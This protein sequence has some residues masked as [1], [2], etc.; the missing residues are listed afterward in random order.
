MGTLNQII[1]LSVNY[2]LPKTQRNI[3][4]YSEMGWNC[5]FVHTQGPD[6]QVVHSNHSLY[7]QECVHYLGEVHPFG[8]TLNHM[9]S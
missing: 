3:L 2:S 5:C 1:W 9:H 4:T 6:P 7:I 8:Q